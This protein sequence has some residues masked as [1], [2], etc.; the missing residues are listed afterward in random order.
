MHPIL[1]DWRRF[2]A[3]LV[4]WALVGTL[5]AGQLVIATARLGQLAREVFT[6][7]IQLGQ[8]C[9]HRHGGP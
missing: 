9:L 6:Q 7:P 5:I 1:A 4:A 2:G 3:Y 8:Q